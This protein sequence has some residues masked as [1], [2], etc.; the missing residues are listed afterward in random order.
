ME[1]FLAQPFTS[2]ASDQD[3]DI[4]GYCS[5]RFKSGQRHCSAPMN[6]ALVCLY[7][8]QDAS[9]MLTRWAIALQ[10]FDFT[11]KHVAGKFNVPDT[12][13]RLFEKS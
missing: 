9:N 12:L 2:S 5:Q 10:N 3:V 8:I 11:V 4:V 13:S 1:L 7:H 6:R